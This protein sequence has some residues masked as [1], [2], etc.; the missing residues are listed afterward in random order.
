MANLPM[1]DSCPSDIMFDDK[2][3]NQPIHHT[4]SGLS[5]N[6]GFDPWCF[7]CS[8]KKSDENKNNGLRNKRNKQFKIA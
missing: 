3:D 8:F 2:L 5:N 1:I 6:V 7:C 4:C